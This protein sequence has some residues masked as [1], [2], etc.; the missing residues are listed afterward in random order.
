[1]PMVSVNSQGSVLCPVLFNIYVAD[2][3][4][5]LFSVNICSFADDATPFVCGLNVKVALTQLE[6]SSK[7]VTA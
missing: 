2:L 5:I 6:E 4:F 7:L 3:F 1:M